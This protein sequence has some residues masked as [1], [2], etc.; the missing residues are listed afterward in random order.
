LLAGEIYAPQK[1][2]VIEVPEAQL[3]GSPGQIVF[4][5]ELGCLCGSD[6]LFYEAD[7]PEFPPVVGHSLHELIGTVVES[8]GTRFGAGDRVL[9]VPDNQEGLFERF[10]VS[11]E[12][13]IPLDS[14][15][16]PEHALLAQP[17]GTVICALRKLPNV[18]DQNVAVV[19]QGPI[20][21]LF[22]GA[23]RNLGAREIIA[24]DPLES[25]LKTS[26]SMG[27]TAVVNNA[28]DDP[29]EAV[30]MITGGAMAD[31]VVEA[32]GHRE[33]AFNLCVSLCRD[34]GQILVFGV[35]PKTVD[36]LHWQSLMVKNINV[37]TSINP[38]FTKDFPLAM[39]WIAEERIDVSPII[40]HRFELR[41]IQTAFETFHQRRDGALKVLV[42][43]P[44]R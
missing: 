8:S 25:R 38:D 33:Q 2:R 12:R 16:A 44:A 36:G 29:A 34:A 32:V 42:D 39:R 37:Q 19:G 40:T 28:Q 30:R 41:E 27:A 4:Q 11:D 26:P 17:L 5:P 10:C 35:P 23:L 20:G 24:I 18:I 6:F 7:Y 21:Q 43:F 3:N 9:C 13:A 31:L 1:I 22:C 15:P 14:R